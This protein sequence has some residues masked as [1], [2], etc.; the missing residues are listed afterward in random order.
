MAN[1][2]L[3]RMLMA[4]TA[5]LTDTPYCMQSGLK[6]IRFTHS[7][8]S[9]SNCSYY[10]SCSNFFMTGGKDYQLTRF[11]CVRWDYITPFVH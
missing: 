3:C 4:M 11:L 7:F 9:L 6:H 2:T 5:A 10:V 8:I 1:G